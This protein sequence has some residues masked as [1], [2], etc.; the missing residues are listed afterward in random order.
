MITS[1]NVQFSYLILHYKYS[2]YEII[3]VFNFSE[4]VWTFA[5]STAP[6]LD[7]GTMRRK[8]AILLCLASL[9]S[10]FPS[11]GYIVDGVNGNDS[12][13]GETVTSPFQTIGRCV[14][15]LANPGDEC[16][17]R[18]GHYHEVVTVSGLQG[19]ENYQSIEVVS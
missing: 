1:P 3:C 10:L 2:K 16:L 12:N 14:E 9:I 8:V 5:L 17:I 18:A 7:S 4:R 13:D 15:A 19:E 6:P 11:E